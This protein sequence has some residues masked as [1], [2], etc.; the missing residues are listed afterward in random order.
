MGLA[1][2]DREAA[3]GRAYRE[4]TWWSLHILRI[5]EHCH[6]VPER[7]RRRKEQAPSLRWL[8][9]YFTAQERY[10]AVPGS[11]GW[12]RARCAI[13]RGHCPPNNNLSFWNIRGIWWKCAQTVRV[14]RTGVLFASLGRNRN[15]FV[16][17]SKTSV[18]RCI[19]SDYIRAMM[20]NF[21]SFQPFS[22]CILH[23]IFPAFCKKT[24]TFIFYPA[25]FLELF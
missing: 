23:I 15:H 8:D 16:F 25:L 11:P 5:F 19:F 10:R 24:F 20:Y 4:K 17:L 2:S 3:F 18:Q 7:L 22:L 13:V 14:L 1:P 9:N 21:S 12:Q 6:L